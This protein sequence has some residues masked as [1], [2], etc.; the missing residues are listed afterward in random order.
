MKEN[1]YQNIA[2]T[3]HI[4]FIRFRVHHKTPF[5]HSQCAHVHCPT[6]PHIHSLLRNYGA[7]F[8]FFVSF[9]SLLIILAYLASLNRKSMHVK[10]QFCLCVL[11]LQILNQLM[12][13]CGK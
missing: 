4:T 10:S 5:E 8:S 1:Y 11:P 7:Y 13:K 3:N 9:L 12:D 2:T 6:T